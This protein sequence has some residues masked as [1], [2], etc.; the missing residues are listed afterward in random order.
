MKLISWNVNGVRACYDKCLPDFLS[1]HKPDIFCMQ[2]TKAWA[3]QVE[4]RNWPKA[5]QRHWYGAEKKG[6]SGTAVF[7]KTAPQ[8]ISFGIGRKEHDNEGRVISA[9][10]EDFWLVNVYTPNV[11][12]DLSRLEYRHKE[13]DPLFLK[14]CK[15]L[16]RKKPVIICGDLN[17]AHKEID[18]ARPKQNAGNAGFTDEEREGMDNIVGAGFIDSFREF[19]SEGGNYSWWSMRAAA[20][21]RNVGWRIDY[22]CVSKKLRPRLKDAFILPEVHGSDHCPV[23]IALK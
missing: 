13:W 12:N 8:S 17:V 2:E 11:K 7:T 21:S 10:Y 5:W 4:D 14:H 18:L 22:F 3:E 16:E 20:R 15:K 23:G 19:N 6:Y 1:K 9:E